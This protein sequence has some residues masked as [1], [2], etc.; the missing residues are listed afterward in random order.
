MSRGRFIDG[1]GG[2]ATG[3]RRDIVAGRQLQQTSQRQ[4]GGISGRD[5]SSHVGMDEGNF[6][7]YSGSRG[8]DPPP[9]AQNRGFLTLD[10][11][12]DFP[13]CQAGL[14]FT[15]LNRPRVAPFQSSAAGL[16]LAPISKCFSIYLAYIK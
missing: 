15:R 4:R 3:T 5:F 7:S 9:P 16:V 14:P 12:L 6:C 2:A 10:Q 13:S 8:P 11:K 1:G